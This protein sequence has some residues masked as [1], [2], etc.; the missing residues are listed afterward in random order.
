MKERGGFLIGK[1]KEGGL[2]SVDGGFSRPCKRAVFVWGMDWIV[3]LKN[4][5]LKK[6]F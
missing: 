2:L 3:G 6:F 5:E 4:F 1:N